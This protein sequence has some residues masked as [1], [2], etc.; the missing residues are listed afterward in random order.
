[1]SKTLAVLLLSLFGTASVSPGVVFQIETTYHGEGAAPPETVEILVEGPNVAIPSVGGSQDDFDGAMIFRGDRGESGE[2]IAVDHGE[3]SY[4]VISEAMIEDV[5]VQIEEAMAQMEEMLARLPQAQRDMIEQAR[6]AGGGAAM[7]M[8]D[9]SALPEIEIRETGDRDTME[10]YPV[11]KFEVYQDDVLQRVVW[12]TPWDQI[13]G[14][15]E[16]R[17]AFLGMKTFFEA[18]MAAMPTASA[19]GDNPFAELNFEFGFPVV[20]QELDDNGD[21]E[22]ES[23]LVGAHRRTIDPAAFEPPSGYTK[24]AMGPG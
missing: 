11:Q 14:G 4:Y 2:M 22:S 24:R 6:K 15:D 17:D 8:P 5:A 13:D 12:A 20:M 19:G 16:A 1:M 10:G 21:L 3:Q 18:M 23:R 9:L 7:G